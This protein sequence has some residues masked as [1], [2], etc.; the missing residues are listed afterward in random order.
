MSL[1]HRLFVMAMLTAALAAAWLG[2]G[3][4]VANFY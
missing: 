2:G 4:L 1:G 3:W